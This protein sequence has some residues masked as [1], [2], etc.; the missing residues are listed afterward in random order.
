MNSLT[1]PYNGIT[2]YAGVPTEQLT[3]RLHYNENLYGP[4]PLCF[5]TLKK[6]TPEDI[7]LYE[8]GP[9]DDLIDAVSAKF[10]IPSEN[11]FTGNG[12][13]ENIKSIISIFTKEGDTVLL[14]DPG[15]SY[16]TGLANYKF[17]KVELYP[18]LEEDGLC[19]HDIATLREKAEKDHPKL[20]IITSPAM[21][22][23]NKI[24][25]EDLEAIIKDFPDSLILVDEAYYGFAD[26]TLDVN[27]IIHTY[28]NVIFS[29]TFSKYYGLAN[30]RIGYGFC[31]E[32]LRK[33]LWLDLPL[34][35]LP[36]I[37]K[38]MAIAALQDTEYYE[39][40]TAELLESRD[41]FI[42]TL[43]TLPRVHAYPSSANFIYISLTNYDVRKIK[44]AAE[45][46]GYLIR[47]FTGNNQEHLRITIGTKDLM[48]DLTAFMLKK[49]P[50]A[51]LS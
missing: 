13:A 38:R 32:E 18:I 27:R 19:K 42:A 37:C 3:G 45:D 35:R 16:Y 30:L 28:D 24:A 46:H 6:V 34:H 26:Y 22:T 51:D 2:R 44:A 12:S 36:H 7:S 29:R 14:P 39:R 20:I 40:I 50:E 11:I 31:S 43:N 21:P 9:R 1:A 10:S 5:E 33:V 41:Q 49:I 15:W 47:I 8:S 17:L 23:G 48:K 4:S 25:D